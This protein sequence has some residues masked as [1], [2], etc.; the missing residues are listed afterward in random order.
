MPMKKRSG[1]PR[2][3]PPAGADRTHAPVRGLRV[4]PTQERSRRRLETIL[5]AAATLFADQG[6]EAVTVDAIAKS[7]GTPI[8]SV[9]QFFADKRAVFVALAERSNLRTEEAFEV[10]ARTALAEPRPPW[11]VMLDAVIDGFAMLS[12]HDPTFRAIN[13]NLGHADLEAEARVHE[14]LVR[15]ATEILALYA[16]TA[17]RDVRELVATT[18]VDAVTFTLV[19]GE[20]R[21]RPLRKKLLDETKTMLRLYVAGRLGVEP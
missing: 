13:R 6:F 11:G 17:T 18:L 10:L 4:V 7:A 1:R 8:G 9:Y 16:P 3:A 20:H 2:S 5:D 19:L 21:S 14:S 12:A 15:R